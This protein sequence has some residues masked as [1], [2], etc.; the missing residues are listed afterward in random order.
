M[1]NYF[2]FLMHYSIKNHYFFTPIVQLFSIFKFLYAQ[3]SGQQQ[4]SIHLS[5]WL[6]ECESGKKELH[7]G[8]LGIGERNDR[9]ERLVQYAYYTDMFIVNYFFKK[10]PCRK[11][12][13]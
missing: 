8:N 10:S 5:K 9:E 11:W 6:L 12:T 3:I 1:S 13:R 2:G 4:K 7:M